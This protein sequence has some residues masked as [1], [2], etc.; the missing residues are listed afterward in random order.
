MILGKSYFYKKV[1]F[2]YQTSLYKISHK[3]RI[4]SSFCKKLTIVPHP[5]ISA[6]RTY[7]LG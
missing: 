3:L 6:V 5:Q 7:E 4:V 2:W 1:F